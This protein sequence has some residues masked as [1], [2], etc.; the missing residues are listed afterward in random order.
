MKSCDRIAQDAFRYY[1]GSLS[2][3][4]HAVITRHLEQCPTCAN[5][6]AWARRTREGLHK[7]P[8]HSPSANFDM[9]LHAQM[10]HAGYEHRSFWPLTMPAWIWQVPAYGAAALLLIGAGVLIDRQLEAPATLPAT[11]Q[12]TRMDKLAAALP[13]AETVQTTSRSS[14]ELAGSG[15]IPLA[16]RQTTRTSKGEL[17]A[18][19]SE[20][21][22]TAPSSHSKVPQLAATQA[23]MKRY[24]MQKIPMQSLLRQ[25]RRAI[26][27]QQ[28]L[29]EQLAFDTMLVHRQ[30]GGSRT[31]PGIRAVNASV[32]F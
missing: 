20:S 27:N 5:A 18:A 19:P 31:L 1:E 6:Y 26:G 11:A 28:T 13:A 4:E 25:N 16:S 14:R 7:L 29:L 2:Q 22:I 21:A 30:N 15:M 32:Q 10:R 9:V 17:T 23:P 3:E 24:V 8:R 12:I